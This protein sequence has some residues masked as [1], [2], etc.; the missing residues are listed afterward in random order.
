V[1]LAV[2]FNLILKRFL[3]LRAMSQGELITIY[4]ILIMAITVSG[5]D[6]SQSIFCTIG[7]SHWFATPEN[8]WESLFWR[9][10]PT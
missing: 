3:P 5:H 10:V 9:Y 2:L 7:T 4:I 8:E 1:L 6:F